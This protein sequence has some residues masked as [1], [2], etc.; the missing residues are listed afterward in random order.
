VLWAGPALHIVHYPLRGGEIF[1]IVAVFRTPTYAGRDDHQAYKR[2]LQDTYRN[3]HPSMQALLQLLE[4]DRRWPIADRKPVRNWASGHTVLL[5]DA[6]HPTLQSYAQGAAMAIEDAFYLAEAVGPEPDDMPEKLKSYV[7]GRV[8]RTSRVQLESRQLW[9]V[10]HYE[11]P[12]AVDVRKDQFAPMRDEDYF[13]CLSWLWDG[14]V[15]N[16]ER[17]PLSGLASRPLQQTAGA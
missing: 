16:S 13:R 12:I 2:E 6:A 15:P 8:V 11:D 4:L 5:G 17:E 3:T 1:N 14:I 7:R 9:E 10:Y